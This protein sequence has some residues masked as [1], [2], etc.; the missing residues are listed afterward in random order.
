LNVLRNV[1]AHKRRVTTGAA[2]GDDQALAIDLTA[3]REIASAVHTIVNI[4]DAP[5]L[6]QSFAILPAIAGAA[7]VVDVEHR[8]S[9]AGPILN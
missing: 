8:K 4:N 3:V 6:V 2:A 9:P 5:L 1:S 7:A